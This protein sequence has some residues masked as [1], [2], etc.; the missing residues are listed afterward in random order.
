MISNLTSLGSWLP[1]YTHNIGGTYTSPPDAGFAGMVIVQLHRL[2]RRRAA[3]PGLPDRQPAPELDADELSAYSPTCL[4][5]AVLGSP[6]DRQQRPRALQHGRL[7][8]ELPA[9]H[10]P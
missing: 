5:R 8:R 3:W 7:P 6:V 4:C 10:D 9:P 2:W 1:G